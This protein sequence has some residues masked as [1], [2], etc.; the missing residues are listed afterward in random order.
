MIILKLLFKSNQN[1]ED[2][3]FYTQQVY[4]LTTLCLFI[5]IWEL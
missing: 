3:Q 4:Y 1:Y 2:C 5:T